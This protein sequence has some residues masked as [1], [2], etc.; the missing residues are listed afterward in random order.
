VDPT[1]LQQEGFVPDELP[2]FELQS[3]SDPAPLSQAVQEFDKSLGTESL[4]VRSEALN[5]LQGQL[6]QGMGDAMADLAS[7]S[8]A[9]ASESS[10]EDPKVS[11][12]AALQSRVDSYTKAIA[13]VQDMIA[14]VDR[15]LENASIGQEQKT[16][17][18]GAMVKFE[19]TFSRSGGEP[20]RAT[21]QLIRAP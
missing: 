7:L 12:Q 20:V 9:S 1:G 15:K 21:I 8:P 14:D 17:A 2:D 11:Q 18:A 3:S 6:E 16:P 5:N 19:P 13:N 10:T 4:H